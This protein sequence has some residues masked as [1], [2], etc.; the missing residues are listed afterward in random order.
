MNNHKS[1]V[2]SV[3]RRN[4]LKKSGSIAVMSLF[5]VSFFTSCADEEEVLPDN[6]ANNNNPSPPEDTGITVNSDSV[7]IDLNQVAVLNNEGGWLLILS[8]QMLVINVGGSFNSLTSVCTHSGCDRNWSLNNNE[9]VCSCHGSRFTT[10]G[11]VVQ[12]PANQPLRQF[13]NSRDGDILTIDRS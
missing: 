5:G 4:F 12:G 3:S 1:G 11:D 8:A 2:L 13:T 9:F 10:S 7:V 6:N